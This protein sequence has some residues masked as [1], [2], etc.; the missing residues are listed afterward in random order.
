[1][2]MKGRK[3]GFWIIATL[4]GILLFSGCEITNEVVYPI[5]IEIGG[6]ESTKI[7]IAKNVI[8]AIKPGLKQRIYSRFPSVTSQQLDTLSFSW[9]TETTFG[10]TSSTKVFIQINLQYTGTL[11]EASAILQF[12]ADE[13]NEAIKKRSQSPSIVLE[14][15]TMKELIE[16]HRHDR[17]EQLYNYERPHDGLNDMTPIE[18]LNAA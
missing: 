14:S 2:F 17:I 12:C 11:D 15:S 4:C 8:Q 5:P 13:A 18:Y 9:G 6:D 7:E 3:Q 10:V 16:S 1:M